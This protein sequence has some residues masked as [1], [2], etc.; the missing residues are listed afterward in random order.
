M[1]LF[2]LC[3]QGALEMRNKTVEDRYTPLDKVY[4]L[5]VNGKL[6]HG[7]MKEVKLQSFYALY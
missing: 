2:F 5:D 6:D 4:M 7:T 1:F 3:L